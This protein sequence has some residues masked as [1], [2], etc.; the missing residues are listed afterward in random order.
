M[1]RLDRLG[2]SLEHLI[3]T[4]THL[5]DR[6]IAFT[7][8]TE[9][10][11]TTT[12]GGKLVCHVFGALGEFVRDLIR[13]CTRGCLAAA[14]PRGRGGGHPK[15]LAAPK[16]VALAQK[17]YVDG[18][19]DV[20]TLCRTLGICRATLSRYVTPPANDL[21]PHRRFPQWPTRPLT[22]LSER[23]RAQAMERYRLLRLHL[24]EGVPLPPISRQHGAVLSTDQRRASPPSRAGPHPATGPSTRSPA[25]FTRGW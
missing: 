23:Q 11:D 6:G 9:E 14:G 17:R 2:R 18:Q 21:P 4:V 1:W 10:I 13:E 19:T 15:K 7:S 25:A 22:S 16:T 24:R 5:R 12:P 8:R 3:E 20:A